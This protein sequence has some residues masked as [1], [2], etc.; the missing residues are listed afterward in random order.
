MVADWILFLVIDLMLELI[1]VVGPS[2]QEEI[3][4]LSSYLDFSRETGI[5][6]FFYFV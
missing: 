6:S 5:V 4:Y 1:K 2:R 3:V